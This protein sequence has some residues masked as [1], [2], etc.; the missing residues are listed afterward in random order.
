MA[1]PGGAHGGTEPRDGH[2]MISNSAVKRSAQGSAQGIAFP[3]TSRDSTFHD[4][5]V[6][7]LDRY[8]QEHRTS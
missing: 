1:G 2:R 7:A 5:R 8:A 3:E 4:A 6:R